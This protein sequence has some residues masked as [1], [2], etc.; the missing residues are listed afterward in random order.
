[1]ESCCESKLRS[2]ESESCKARMPV[3]HCEVA[4]FNCLRWNNVC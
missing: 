3:I 2:E 4:A 1:M